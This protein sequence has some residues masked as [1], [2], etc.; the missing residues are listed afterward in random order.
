MRGRGGQHQMKMTVVRVVGWSAGRLCWQP[1]QTPG[2][3]AQLIKLAQ[4]CGAGRLPNSPH[5]RAGWGV[6]SSD[7][8]AQKDVSS[9]PSFIAS[10]AFSS[11]ISPP[12][13]AAI[14][15]EVWPAVRAAAANGELGANSIQTP[16]AG[17]HFG[18]HNLL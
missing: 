3:M 7:R 13:N 15:V 4:T 6:D 14:H 1:R 2:P 12:S 18:R 17:P 10:P 9:E 16:P 5:S 11:S 8:L